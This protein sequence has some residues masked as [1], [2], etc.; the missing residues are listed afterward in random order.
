MKQLALIAI[1]ALVATP[2][3]ADKTHSEATQMA[4]S[5][6]A[7]DG[8]PAAATPERKTCRTFAN[9]ANR[10]SAIKL[11]LTKEGWRKFEEQQAQP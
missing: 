2:A 5:P 7:Q 3:L 1:G 6:S 10:V 8:A 11:C 4:A 9:S